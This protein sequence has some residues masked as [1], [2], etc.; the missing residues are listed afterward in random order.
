ML[1]NP[2]P[3]NQREGKE[4]DVGA[5]AEAYEVENAA[6]ASNNRATDIAI[7]QLVRNTAIVRG[8]L[9]SCRNEETMRFGI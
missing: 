2:L 5:A 1:V 9:Q 3:R 7:V 4:L 8:T 6:G